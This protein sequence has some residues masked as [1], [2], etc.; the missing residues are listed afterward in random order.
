MNAEEI[1]V[2]EELKKSVE[3]K[4]RENI[5]EWKFD[6][7]KIPSSV[8]NQFL[9]ERIELIDR[10]EGANCYSNGDDRA[11]KEL[12][13]EIRGKAK[14]NALL[15][16]EENGTILDSMNF[17][18]N[19]G[20]ISL[21]D[22][23]NSGAIKW[24]KGQSDKGRSVSI[25]HNHPGRIAAIPSIGDLAMFDFDKNIEADID[26]KYQLGTTSTYEEFIDNN[27]DESF[28]INNI[29]VVTKLDFFSIKLNDSKISEYAR[30]AIEEQ[31]E[32]DKL[33][34][35]QKGLLTNMYKGLMPS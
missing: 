10:F 24:I 22:Y 35:S 6:I 18:G 20:E 11:L 5:E 2:F 19:E 30:K 16:S 7:Q 32:L 26:N 28:R 3:K 9:N 34:N 29:G 14:E 27:I 23:I 1:V 4:L 25:Y 31:N 13:E 15:V 8:F 12:L 17:E 33:A 21:E